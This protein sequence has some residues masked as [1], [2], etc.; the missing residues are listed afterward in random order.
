MRYS[1]ADRGEELFI[2]TNEG[3]A[4]DFKIVTAPLAAPDRTQW[5]E[6]VPHRP[7]T[8]IL[9]IDLFAGHL[10]RLERANALP[11]ISIRDLGTQAEHTIAF[12]ETAYSLDMVGGFEFDT[13]VMRFAYSSMTTPSEIYDYDMATRQRTL[14]KRQEIPSGHDPAAYVTTRILACAPDGAEVPVSI[15]HR[16]DLVRDGRATAAPLRLRLLRHGHAGLV[17]RQPPVAGRSRV[18]SMRSLISGAAPTRAGRGISTASAR[19]RPTRST[20]S[21]PRAVP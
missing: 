16:R 10:V 8:Y 14:R 4:I 20:I 18:S 15:L 12:D 13:T 7:G 11:S 5:R 19:R 2:L 3:G 6:L 17:L 1:V 21:S 9:G